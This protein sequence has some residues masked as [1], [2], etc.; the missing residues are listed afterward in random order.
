MLKVQK[1]YRRSRYLY[2]LNSFQAYN[3]NPENDYLSLQE[4]SSNE[5][6]TLLDHTC[7]KLEYKQTLYSIRRLR[8]LDLVLMDLERELEQIAENK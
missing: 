4:I 5:F 8:E 1:F 3:M 7:I 2:W 6:D